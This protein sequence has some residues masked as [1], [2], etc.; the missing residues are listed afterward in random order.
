MG[1]GNKIQDFRKLNI[2]EKTTST[3]K[4]TKKP[5]QGRMKN[6]SNT[7]TIKRTRE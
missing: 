1:R 6:S 5:I 7:S 3:K 4:T 2:S